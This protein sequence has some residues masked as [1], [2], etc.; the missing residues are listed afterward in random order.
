MLS[1]QRILNY[2]AQ[3]KLNLKKT[4]Y[5]DFETYVHSKGLPLILLAPR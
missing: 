2:L 4:N 1:A 3:I 5:S